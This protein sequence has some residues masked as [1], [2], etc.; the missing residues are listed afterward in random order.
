MPER[1]RA[2]PSG[3]ADR[4]AAVAPMRW[5]FQGTGERW[6]VGRAVAASPLVARLGAQ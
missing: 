3:E 2:G 5:D 4:P 6:L 1:S